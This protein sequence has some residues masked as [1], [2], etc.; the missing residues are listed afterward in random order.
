MPWYTWVPEVVIAASVLLYF[1]IRNNIARAAR[2]REIM[3]KTRNELETELEAVA[4]LCV[5]KCPTN[6][7]IFAALAEAST[8]LYSAPPQGGPYRIVG[9]GDWVRWWQDG[10]SRL[11]A[12]RQ[13]VESL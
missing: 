12:I 13:Q 10:L 5:A 4:M 7:Q 8:R 2:N 1:V 3:E 9:P 6:K 11:K